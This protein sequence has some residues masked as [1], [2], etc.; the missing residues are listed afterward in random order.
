M[1]DDKLE[2][3][4]SA[5]ARLIH[6]LV[7]VFVFSTFG[8]TNPTL[9][10]PDSTT[11]YFTR[12]PASMFDV[13]MLRLDLR[14]KTIK[15]SSD[16]PSKYPTAYANYSFKDDEIII[17]ISSFSFKGTNSEAETYCSEWVRIIR[18]FAGIDTNTGKPVY[19]HSHFT[20]LFS[21]D[22]YTNEPTDNALAKLDPKFL[23]SCYLLGMGMDG[24][25]VSITAPLLGTSYS[26][27][28]EQSQ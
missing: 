19:A 16:Y 15:D 26:I 17:A 23:L 9:A 1:D 13:G 20:E 2:Y 21:H 7:F 22:G 3:V 24:K 10:G 5:L 27:E 28:K 25:A 11:S 4:D 18:L 12:T 8:F 14:L 6:V